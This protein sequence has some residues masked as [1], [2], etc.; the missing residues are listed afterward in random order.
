MYNRELEALPKDKLKKLQDE[1]LHALVRYVYERV[2]F[3]KTALDE[4]DV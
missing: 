3:Y 2:P 1:R 4:K